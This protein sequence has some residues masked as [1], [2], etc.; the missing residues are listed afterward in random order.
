M[1]WSSPAPIPDAE[2]AVSWCGDATT[3]V[4][5]EVVETSWSTEKFKIWI[6]RDL[7]S[8]PPVSLLKNGV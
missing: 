7:L 1:S 8:T 3:I 6:K 2:T 4:P 5:A